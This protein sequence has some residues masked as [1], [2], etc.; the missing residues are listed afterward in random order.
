ML[1]VIIWVVVIASPF[2]LLIAIA[3]KI[4]DGG[5]VFYKQPR[6][7]RDNQIFMILKFRSMKIDSEEQGAQLANPCNRQ[8]G[9]K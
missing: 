1:I 9:R 8:C 7:T 2:M 3:I 4:Y 5:P 6:L